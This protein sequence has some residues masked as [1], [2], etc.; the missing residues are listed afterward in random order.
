MSPDNP[1]QTSKSTLLKPEIRNL[2]Y[3]KL[4][5]H[6]SKD[7][8]SAFF[9]NNRKTE[10]LKEKSKFEY[11]DFNFKKTQW[12]YDLNS[13]S[14]SHLLDI[15]ADKRPMIKYKSPYYKKYNEILNNQGFKRSQGMFTFQAGHKQQITRTNSESMRNLNSQVESL[16][17]KHNDSQILKAGKKI[18]KSSSQKSLISSVNDSSRISNKDIS[19]DLENA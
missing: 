19:S 8:D 5:L 9:L 4:S 14:P 13:L 1:L 6:N 11:Q 18:I 2:E 12:T 15:L 7:Q 3:I 16:Q 17:K 10:H